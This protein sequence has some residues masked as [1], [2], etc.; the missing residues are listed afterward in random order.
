MR[1]KA[2]LILLWALPVLA[3]ESHFEKGNQAYARGQY[4]NAVSEYR[5]LLDAN[6]TSA[7]VHFNLANTFHQISRERDDGQVQG[8]TQLGRA[9]YHYRMARRLSPRPRAIT[10][11]LQQAR[12]RVHGQAPREGAAQVLLGFLTINEW[13]IAAWLA[14]TAWLGLMTAG[15]VRPGWRARWRSWLPLLGGAGLV[16]A[17]LA[18]WAWRMQTTGNEAVAILDTPVFKRPL[19]PEEVPDKVDHADPD[20]LRDGIEMCI[21]KR[22]EDGWLK[23]A[24]A[25]G[26]LQRSGWV[27]EG[28]RARPNLLVFPR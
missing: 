10:A 27:R 21:I 5:Q 4:E 19:A 8:A 2:P 20:P 1:F 12:E 11:N 18:G 3:G 24:F 16:L 25:D 13:A 28:E 15:C 23:V 9:I 6:R 22:R 14:L 17:L 26:V 7:A